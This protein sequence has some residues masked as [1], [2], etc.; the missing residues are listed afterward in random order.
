MDAFAAPAGPVIESHA[1]AAPPHEETSDISVPD[2][3]ILSAEVDAMPDAAI[4]STIHGSDSSS[5][6]AATMAAEV[7]DLLR[8]R[9]KMLDERVVEVEAEA[10]TTVAE[11][12]IQVAHATQVPVYRQRLI[13]RGRS[14]DPSCG[15]THRVG[16]GCVV[17]FQYDR[18]NGV[19]VDFH[20]RRLKNAMEQIAVS[21]RQQ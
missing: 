11:F 21:L 17:I 10:S 7:S 9:L 5:S 19:H 15:E 8:L 13:Y 14:Y 4:E 2:A 1:F 12:R 18:R 6:G 16:C 20:R 3:E